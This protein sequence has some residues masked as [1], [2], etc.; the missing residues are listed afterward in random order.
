MSARFIMVDIVVN[1]VVAINTDDA[2][3]STKLKADGVLWTDPA[4]YHSQCWIDYNNQTSVENCWMGDDKLAL[5]DVNTESTK[6]QEVL[7]KY[8]HD[9]VQEYSIDGLRIDGECFEQALLTAQPP[10]M[11][12]VLSGQLS[13]V[14][15]VSFVPVKFMATTSSTSLVLGGANAD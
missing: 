2:K 10:S 8:I 5:M 4:D 7:F 15:Q 14:P 9:F 6:I 1:N 13:A 12:R 11:S 3:N